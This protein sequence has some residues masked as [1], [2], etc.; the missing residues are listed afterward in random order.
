MVDYIMLQSKVCRLCGGL[1]HPSRWLPLH[2]L[3][4]HPAGG[5]IAHILT[6]S[7]LFAAQ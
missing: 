2:V 3:F 5:G 6:A 7:Y 4:L 1:L